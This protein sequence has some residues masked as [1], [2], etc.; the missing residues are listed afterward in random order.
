[1]WFKHN[2]PHEIEIDGASMHRMFASINDFSKKVVTAIGRMFHSM[3]DELFAMYREKRF[4]HFLPPEFAVSRKVQI[5]KW[6]VF[7]KC[8]LRLPLNF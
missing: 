7:Y 4:R 2:H 3:D 5:Y 8:L 1:M 6:N